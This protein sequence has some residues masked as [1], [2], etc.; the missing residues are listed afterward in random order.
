MDAIIDWV[1][2]NLKGLANVSFNKQGCNLFNKMPVVFAS[3]TDLFSYYDKRVILIPTDI[4]VR[5]NKITSWQVNFANITLDLF[6]K[7]PCPEG[8]RAIPNQETPAWWQS[9]GGTLLPAWNMWSVIRGLM[10]FHEEEESNV[11]DGHSRFPIEASPRH[12]ANL[13][14][15]P[16]IN[17]ALALLIDAAAY[18]QNVDD[19]AILSGVDDYVAPPAILLSHD[20]DN[21]TGNSV[22]TQIAR[23]SKFAKLVL[24]GKVEAF[25]HLSFI[26]QNFRNPKSFYYDDQINMWKS[27]QKYGFSSVVYILN[28]DGG[29][30]GARTPFSL[31]AK[32]IKEAP[33]EMEIGIHYNYGYIRN[34]KKLNKQLEE[35]KSIKNNKVESGRAHYL[36]FDPTIDFQMLDEHNI[37]FDESVG[38]PYINSY[39]AGIAGPFLPFDVKNNAPYSVLELPMTF[40]DTDLPREDGSKDTFSAM[41]DHI[42]KVG[43]CLSILV[44]PGACDNPERKDM[45]G[46]YGRILE[47]L[48]KHNARS[49]TPKSLRQL[50]ENGPE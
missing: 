50:W 32:L 22:W 17:N 31:S 30:F 5:S 45:K 10:L 16:I 9:P 25:K 29:R 34:S 43:G 18:I 24:K 12:K 13:T 48:S 1:V 44:H 27:Q 11:R 41:L 15:V 28:G 37:R 46:V 3:Q 2:N 33:K 42:R 4:P 14:H 47:E 38:W 26:I 35:I 39:R 36:Y 8:W 20:C 21:L 6:H 7:T 40:M 23:L 19:H 49:Y